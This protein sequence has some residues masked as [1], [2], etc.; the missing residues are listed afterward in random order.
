VAIVNVISDEKKHHDRS[1]LKKIVEQSDV[2]ALVMKYEPEKA[3]EVVAQNENA[4]R[5]CCPFPDHADH[6]PS[7]RIF[8][9]GTKKGRWVCSCGAGNLFDF[10]MRAEQV[11]F[12][13]ALQHLKSLLPGGAL[14]TYFNADQMLK[15]VRSLLNSEA[16][17]SFECPS[18]PVCKRNHKMIAWYM[19]WR[20]RY[21]LADALK[22]IERDG[23]LWCDDQTKY[24]AEHMEYGICYAPS[25]VI[26]MHD[27]N[28]KMVYWQ[29]QYVDG[30]SGKNKLYPIGSWN[31]T[32]LPGMYMCI[33]GGF[34]WALLV[35][36]YWD[37]V[38]AWF[39]GVP[40]IATGTAFVNDHQMWA[41]YKHL[42]KIVTAYDNDDAGREAAKRVE[43]K[44]GSLIDVSHLNV[45]H[46]KF[47]G[48]LDVDEM[49]RDQLYSYVEGAV[50]SI[51]QVGAINSEK[52]QKQS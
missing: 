28:G 31:P 7:F 27:E 44:L 8:T 29:A 37:M 47:I 42:D 22:I 17:E 2:N 4:I 13:Q 20:R 21:S 11:E 18:M 45:P 50:E 3:R 35:E 25:I 52:T 41:L 36:G 19:N 49:S 24:T 46:K 26:P 34:K 43:E 16:Q 10:V 39:Y 40:A 1:D 32:L 51:D 33:K 9:S 14:D 48:K 23:L 15:E 5:S 12:K 38:R 6:S 30:R